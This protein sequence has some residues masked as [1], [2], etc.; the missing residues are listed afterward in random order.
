MRTVVKALLD[1]FLRGGPGLAKCGDRFG[2]EEGAAVLKPLFEDALAA[3]HEPPAGLFPL[4]GRDA[5]P[6]AAVV[7]HL[8]G[9][10]FQV[11]ARSQQA[12]ARLQVK[13]PVVPVAYK[14]P[15]ADAA[16][17]HG[18]AH[19][20]AAIVNGV[21]G[22]LVEKNREVNAFDCKGPAL[23]GGKFARRCEPVIDAGRWID[24]NRR[25]HLA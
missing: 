11:V 23:A 16:F 15:V 9:K 20:R 14:H 3:R 5:D 7:A 4:A 17:G 12:A 13:F 18:V 22:P 19:V 2:D 10:G 1:D 6:R 21:K 25:P 8:H 24:I